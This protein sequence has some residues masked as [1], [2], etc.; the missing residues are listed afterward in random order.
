MR[1]SWEKWARALD[2][3]KAGHGKET[4]TAAECRFCGTADIQAPLAFIERF[5]SRR[6][7]KRKET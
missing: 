2:C 7:I 3:G 6:V 1:H 5:A 4:T